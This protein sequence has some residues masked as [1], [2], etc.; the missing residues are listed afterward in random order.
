MCRRVKLL[1]PAPAKICKG[2]KVEHATTLLTYQS[3]SEAEERTSIQAKGANHS[4]L[5]TY[6]IS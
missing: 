2:Q 5:T 4:Y 3:V 1:P 6:A